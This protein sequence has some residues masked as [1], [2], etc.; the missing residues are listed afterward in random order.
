MKRPRRHHEERGTIVGKAK[1]PGIQQSIYG[2]V[3]KGERLII[4]NIV[5]E[6]I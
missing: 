3:K 2:F 6:L 1:M 4:A 5:R